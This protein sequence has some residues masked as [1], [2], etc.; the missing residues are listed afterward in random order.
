MTKAIGQGARIYLAQHEIEY[1]AATLANVRDYSAR[2]ISIKMEKHLCKV[3][4]SEQDSNREF[5]QGALQLSSVPK[6]PSANAYSDQAR[7]EEILSQA[8]AG[9]ALSFEDKAWY[10]ERTGFSL[11]STSE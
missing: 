10:F 8:L 7:E 1:L 2:T 6:I 3:Q 4:A 11:D 9:E 5:L